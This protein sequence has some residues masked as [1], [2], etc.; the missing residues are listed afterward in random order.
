MYGADLL[1]GSAQELDLL[2]GL[3]RHAPHGASPSLLAV[4]RAW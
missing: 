4:L 1:A 3:F 2:F